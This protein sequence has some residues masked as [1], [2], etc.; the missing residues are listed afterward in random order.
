MSFGL[1]ARDPGYPKR[2]GVCALAVA[3]LHAAVA[4][5]P[6]PVGRDW[7]GLVSE[8][9]FQG[10]ALVDVGSAGGLDTP[11]GS[12][13]PEAETEAAAVPAEPEIVVAAETDPP[14]AEPVDGDGE[15]P[16]P[17]GAE[18][19]GGGSGP[20]TDAGSG[21]DGLA[22]AAGAG[23]GRGAL[24]QIPRRQAW[25]EQPDVIR[26]RKID[27]YV[28][29]KA[30]V[31]PDGQVLDVEVLRTIADCEECTAS[32]V[33]AVRKYRYDPPLLDGRPA[34]WSEP[35]DVRFTYHR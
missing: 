8:G 3:L 4:L 1:R 26:K 15:S 28:L 13:G 25:P 29:L 32:A 14:P 5:L 22:A 30:L 16:N 7:T 23:G 19:P 24:N 33:A 21:G 12:T 35:F 2:L 10:L 31:G 18:Q 9:A 27:D 17:A 20:G 11:S 34:I 6:W